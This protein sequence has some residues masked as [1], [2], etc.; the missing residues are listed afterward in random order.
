MMAIITQVAANPSTYPRIFTTQA[1][2]RPSGTARGG[3]GGCGG[4]VWELSVGIVAPR[5]AVVANRTTTVINNTGQSAPGYRIRMTAADIP[6]MLAALTDLNGYK[7]TSRMK[8][9][10]SNWPC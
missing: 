5:A 10:G 1:G 2:Q 4:L 8:T 9:T 7:T 3:T 6:E